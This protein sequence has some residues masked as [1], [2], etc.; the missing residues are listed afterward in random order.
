MNMYTLPR[1]RDNKT[2]TAERPLL[3]ESGIFNL[4]IV[5]IASGKTYNNNDCRSYLQLVRNE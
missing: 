3:S 5:F 1:L 2:I 4:D